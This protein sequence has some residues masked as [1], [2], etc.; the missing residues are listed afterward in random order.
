MKI[1]KD[2]GAKKLSRAG[3]KNNN[4]VNS[5]SPSGVRG[6][7]RGLRAAVSLELRKEEKNEQEK[8]IRKEKE[9]KKERGIESLW[10]EKVKRRRRGGGGG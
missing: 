1:K 6:Y 2:R 4:S 9:E 3:N 10:Y 7:S 8:S 5:S